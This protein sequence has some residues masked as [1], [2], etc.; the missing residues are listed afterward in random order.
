VKII[1]LGADYDRICKFGT[2]TD[3]QDHLKL[4]VSNI[5]ELYEKSLKVPEPRTRDRFMLQGSI[6]AASTQ[7]ALYKA[8]TKFFDWMLWVVFLYIFTF[9]V[10]SETSKYW[11]MCVVFALVWSTLQQTDGRIRLRRPFLSILDRGVPLTILF[12][13]NYLTYRYD[14]F[15]HQYRIFKWLSYLASSTMAC[16]ASFVISSLISASKLLQSFTTYWWFKTIATLRFFKSLIVLFAY[17]MF[18]DHG[19]FMWGITLECIKGL[20]KYL[21]I[22]FLLIG[23]FKIF[24]GYNDGPWFYG[25]YFFWQACWFMGKHGIK[26]WE[27]QQRENRS[28]TKFYRSEEKFHLWSHHP[29]RYKPIPSTRHI[30]LLLIHARHPLGPIECSLV[31]VPIDDA[32]MFEAI[33]YTVFSL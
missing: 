30:R 13:L 24:W 14:T 25:N 6:R 10:A 11:K 8:S 9:S 29:Y 27:K 5:K 17:E 23:Y 33:S 22:H 2:S 21:G 3:D 12:I 1:K 7:L 19:Q 15:L 28:R 31:P 20:G 32:P 4:V 16:L 18:I 26:I